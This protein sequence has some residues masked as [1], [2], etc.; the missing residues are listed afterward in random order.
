MHKLILTIAFALVLPLPASLLAETSLDDRLQSAEQ[1]IQG[2][3]HRLQNGETAGDN[4]FDRLEITGLIEI[5]AAW[6]DPDNGNS[7]SSLTLATAELGIAA[8][9]TS[10]VGTELVLLYEDDGAEE[11]DVDVAAITLT[12]SDTWSLSAGQF[13]LPFG[14]YET[15][16]ISDPLTLELGEIRETA[17]QVDFAAG[18]FSVS[19]YIF[20]GDAS[21]NGNNKVDNFGFDLSLALENDSYDLSASV[22]YINDIGDSDGLIDHATTVHDRV[23]GYA[24]SALFTTGPFTVI[25]EYLAA[26]KAFASGIEPSAYNIEA[27]YGFDLA[28]REANAAIGFQGTDD[29]D[30]LGYPESVIIAALSMEIYES[31][32]LAFEIAQTEDYSSND[33]NLFTVQLAAEF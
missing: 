30:P 1:R 27:G 29:A 16:M 25:G 14:V 9:I 10:V 15:Q 18:L 6:E 22:D 8:Q 24:F 31:A 33:T 21:T 17:L 4:W 19:A 5:E 13:Y 32:S 11:L 12:P 7:E 23:A 26:N 28:G 2:L 3:E 20:D